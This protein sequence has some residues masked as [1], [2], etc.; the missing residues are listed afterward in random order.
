MHGIELEISV[1]Y[2]IHCDMNQCWELS[3]CFHAFHSLVMPAFL[4]QLCPYF[5]P[6][7]NDKMNCL[8]R[9]LDYRLWIFFHEVVLVLSP[10]CYHRMNVTWM[11]C[12]HECGPFWFFQLRNDF[13]QLEDAQ[14]YEMEGMKSEVN[15]LTSDLHRR[16]F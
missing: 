6:R 11:T 2:L 8:P 10:C 14:S 1:R 16:Y 15:V 7:R 12:K 13:Q 9:W 4:T 3:K 5:K